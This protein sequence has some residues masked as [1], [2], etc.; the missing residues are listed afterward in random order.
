M[1]NV[2]ITGFWP[3]FC[4]AVAAVEL[5][6]IRPKNNPCKRRETVIPATKAEALSTPY[7]GLFSSRISMII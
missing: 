7:F 4:S 6:K 5:V 1:S 3:L 2:E